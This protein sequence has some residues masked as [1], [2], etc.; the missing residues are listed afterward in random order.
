LC[1]REAIV[2][3]SLAGGPGWLGRARGSQDLHLGVGGGVLALDGVVRHAAT[4]R[5]EGPA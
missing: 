2:L 4:R 5:F 3:T 1:G